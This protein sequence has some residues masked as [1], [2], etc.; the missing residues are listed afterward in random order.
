MNY[1][2]QKGYKTVAFDTWYTVSKPKGL[3]N[4]DY[5]LNYLLDSK[6]SYIDAF[7]LLLINGTM[8]RPFS[9]YFKME[10]T[11]VDNLSRNSIEFTFKKLLD[12]PKINGPKFVFA[13]ILCPHTPFI[14]DQNGEEVDSYNRYNWKEKKYYLNQYIYV[15]K[16]MEKIVD[17]LLEQS[18]EPPIIIVQSDHGPRPNFGQNPNQRF[19]IPAE[20]MYKIFNAYYLPGDAKEALNDRISPVNTFRIIF[21]RYFGE[22]FEILEE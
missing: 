13:H 1:L 3:I 12:M 20:E 15:S 4:A 7:S 11:D 10:Y 14:F 19:Q 5:N 22:K 2:K 9:Y 18:K 6:V 21:N 17:V 8:L 16:Q